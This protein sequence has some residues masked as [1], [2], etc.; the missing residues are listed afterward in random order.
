MALVDE[1]D[2]EGMVGYAIADG[3]GKRPSS[4]DLALMITWAEAIIKGILKLAVLVDTYGLLKVI[5]LS[6][7]MRMIREQRSLSNPDDYL[8]QDFTILP[9]EERLIRMAASGWQAL[10]FDVGEG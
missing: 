10:T 5:E 8:P 1:T 3:N 4:T 7:I 6:I 2:V 9:T